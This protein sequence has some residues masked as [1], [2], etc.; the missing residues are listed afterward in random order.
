MKA[1]E[2]PSHVKQMNVILQAFLIRDCVMALTL[3]YHGVYRINKLGPTTL[4]CGSGEGMG[5]YFTA[6]WMQGEGEGNVNNNTQVKRLQRFI[7]G[8]A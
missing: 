8:F 3:K 4:L 1:S 7:P 2:F 6:G 5:Q